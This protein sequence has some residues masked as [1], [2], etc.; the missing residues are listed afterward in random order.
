MLQHRAAD[1]RYCSTFGS[2]DFMRV[3]WPAARIKTESGF[4]TG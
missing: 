2:A 3:P 4:F 1:D